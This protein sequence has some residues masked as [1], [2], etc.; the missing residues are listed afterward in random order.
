MSITKYLW[1]IWGC[2]CLMTFDHYWMAPYL[3][4]VF[5]KWGCMSAPG[6]WWP[7]GSLSNCTQAPRTSYPHRLDQSQEKIA[8]ENEAKACCFCPDPLIIGTTD[9]GWRDCQTVR[10]LVPWSFVTSIHYT[11]ET[12][13]SDA[14]RSGESRRTQKGVRF[15]WRALEVFSYAQYGENQREFE[16]LVSRAPHVLLRMEWGVFIKEYDRLFW[17][18]TLQPTGHCVNALH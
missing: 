4:A 10:F 7:C 16:P 12:Q 13:S 2:Y 1:D 15:D 8:R 11:H 3:V 9:T 17:N 5:D 6:E 18:T 14:M